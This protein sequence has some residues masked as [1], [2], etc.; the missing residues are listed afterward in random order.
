MMG[1]AEKATGPAQSPA[2][3]LF[4]DLVELEGLVRANESEQAFAALARLLAGLEQRKGLGPL[5]ERRE[6]LDNFATR[7]VLA[8]SRLLGDPALRLPGN[9]Y[10]K[11]ANHHQ[12]LTALARLSRLGSLDDI[13]DLMARE[14]GFGRA[15][16]TL[17]KEADEA[18]KLLL[19]WSLHSRY[20]LGWGELL[21]R[22]PENALPLYLSLIRTRVVLAPEAERRRN[23]LVGLGEQAAKRAMV[24]TSLVQ[25]LRRA[26]ML[27]SYATN[28]DRHRLK[29]SL[30]RLIA[31][32]IKNTG[33]RQPALPRPRP[34]A[35]RP[36]I[37]VGAEILRSDHA[38][39][40]CYAT[41]FMELKRGF[42]LVVAARPNLIDPPASELFDQVIEARTLREVVGAIG[43]LRPDLIFYPSLGMDDWTV[44]CANLRLA[45]IQMASLG[46]PATTH[47]P[48]IDYLVMGTALF[49]GEQHFSEKI[50]LL[51]S[52]GNHYLPHPKT[53]DIVP[54]FRERPNP[55]RIAV[56]S[57]VM[58]LNATFLAL[59]RRLAERA[60]RPVQF[61]FFPGEAG[62]SH[63]YTRHEILRWL[64]DAEVHPT[65]AYGDYMRNLATCDVRLATFPF[66]GANSN[67][68]GFLLGIPAVVYRAGEPHSLTDWRLARLMAQP[69]WLTAEDEPAY[70]RA[71]LRLIDDDAARIEVARAILAAN[72]REAIFANPR[73]FHADDYLDL[74]SWIY[75][76]HEQVQKDGRKVWR[77]EDRRRVDGAS[78]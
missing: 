6:L 61:V 48:Q 58:K 63:L 65:A 40:R 69:E 42:R 73:D 5:A 21:E 76:H 78:G 27:C 25:S 23:I 77:W 49:G 66:G 50:L 75:R 45:P 17:P 38:M 56:V 51:R 43:E 24:P 59:C 54:Q 67:V 72:P 2:R 26:W 13:L 52:A 11:L 70:E 9:T 39:F 57:K 12:T 31:D 1:D 28:P 10:E 14:D 74:F 34:R 60:R 18:R 64:P 37:L 19:A 62:F 15:A 8:A 32:W 53:P 30:N 16:I 3:A 35:A 68:D 71:A 55:L 29:S 7:A 36:T 20:E 4:A 33:Y 47:S 44:V 22:D 41:Y 46:H